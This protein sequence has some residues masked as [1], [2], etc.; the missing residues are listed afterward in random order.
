MGGDV[1]RAMGGRQNKG[2]LGVRAVGGWVYIFFGAGGLG[3]IGDWEFFFGAIR[4]PHAGRRV[5]L[6]VWAWDVCGLI[7]VGLHFAG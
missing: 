3:H 4:G 7:G 6:C 2:T 5:G 1:P